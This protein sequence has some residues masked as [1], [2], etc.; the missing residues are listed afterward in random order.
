MFFG[1][2]MCFQIY[3]SIKIRKISIDSGGKEKTKIKKQNM[4]LVNFQKY[5]D[6]APTHSERD[7]K[8]FKAIAR[9]R[10]FIFYI[11]GAI[12]TDV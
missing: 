10:G 8:L 11:M 3:C 4:S 7:L 5:G 12:K 6:V 9:Y 2:T 1:R